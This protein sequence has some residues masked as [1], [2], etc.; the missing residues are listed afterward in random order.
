[1][2]RVYIDYEYAFSMPEEEYLRMNLYELNEITQDDIKYIKEKVN[3]N[4]A[5]QKG[6]RLLASRAR[7]AFEVRERL[8]QQGFDTDVA[9]NA[10]MQL[11]ALGYIN[12]RLFA[13]KYIS[14]R[15]KLKPK[16]KKAM[17]MELKRKGVDEEIIEET[18]DEFELDESLIAYRVARKKFGKYDISDPKV[19]R[20]IFSFLSFRG[21]SGSTIRAVI[22]QMMEQ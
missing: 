17:A 5:K 19:Q 8:I 20:K 22:N 3:I 9:E 2:V 13:H 21:F 11:K 1:M 4:L 14:D 10:V 6:I 7:S 15:L 18:L 12:D 16:S